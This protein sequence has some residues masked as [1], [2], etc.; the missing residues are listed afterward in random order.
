MLDRA[1]AHDDPANFLRKTEMTAV[2]G[3]RGRAGR[4]RSVTAVLVRRGPPVAA[5]EEE[6]EAVLV[7]AEGVWSV[8]RVADVGQQR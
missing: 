4:A 6:G 1:A 5:A 8:G 7:G 2:R 3:G